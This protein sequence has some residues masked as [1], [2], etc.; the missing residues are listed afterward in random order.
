MLENNVDDEDASINYPI[1]LRKRSRGPGSPVY[2]LVIHHTHTGMWNTGDNAWSK[3][4]T[5]YVKINCAT[6]KTKIR[7]YLN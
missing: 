7:T 4:K 2:E 1:L 3:T 6:C 5:E